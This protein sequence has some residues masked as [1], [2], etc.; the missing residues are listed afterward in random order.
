[1]QEAADE[2]QSSNIQ[3]RWSKSKKV[4]ETSKG[5]A[6]AKIESEGESGQWHLVRRRRRIKAGSE[7]S[8]SLS[9]CISGDSVCQDV[10]RR[11]RQKT[12]LDGTG[13]QKHKKEN[14]NITEETDE[15]T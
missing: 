12:E 2:V 1:M 13:L 14:K 9:P 10:E 5:R 3:R 4:A 15:D 11:K 8:E 6:D 7:C